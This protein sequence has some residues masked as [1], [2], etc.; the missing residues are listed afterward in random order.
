MPSCSEK[1]TLIRETTKASTTPVVI[2]LK[3]SGQMRG[4]GQTPPLSRARKAGTKLPREILVQN[5]AA[6]EVNAYAAEVGDAAGSS[7]Q[8]GKVRFPFGIY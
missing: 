7:V 8:Q 3:S 4:A 2:P 6:R 5:E 1:G